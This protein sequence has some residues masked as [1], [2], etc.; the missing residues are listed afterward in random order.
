M[1]SSL[2][3]ARL[4][5]TATGISALLSGLTPELAAWRPVPGQWNLVEIAAHLLDE[6]REDF[7]IRID[8]TL[9]RPGEAWP[10]IDPAGWVADRRYAER[11]LVATVEAFRHERN[12]SIAWLRGLSAP[13]WDAAYDH[14]QLGTLRAG[15]L[16]ASW[17]GHDLLHLR[18][19]LRR[20]WEFLNDQARPFS[21]DY[22][23][24]W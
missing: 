19:I 5:Q 14:P 22:A 17:A 16:L 13:V 2:L 9:H 8:H 1:E 7:R 4:E 21:L 24:R 6:E 10:P 23:G 3:I 18:Q 20:Q 11:D 15:D 12:R